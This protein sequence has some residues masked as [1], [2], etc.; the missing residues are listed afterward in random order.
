MEQRNHAGGPAEPGKRG[1]H[2]VGSERL[3]KFDAES[4]K[5]PRRSTEL[6]DHLP[7]SLGPFS[8]QNA[9][10]A[11]SHQCNDSCVDVSGSFEICTVGWFTRI[12]RRGQLPN[13]FSVRLYSHL[14]QSIDSEGTR[15]SQVA[16]KGIARNSSHFSQLF[17][18]YRSVSGRSARGIPP[19]TA[20]KMAFIFLN[21][22][23]S[24]H[25]VVVGCILRSN[26]TDENRLLN[27]FRR[28][29]LQRSC[30]VSNVPVELV[31]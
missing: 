26:V 6:R 4:E 28:S 18:A 5:G 2:S 16:C 17:E 30:P 15:N 7:T 12:I 1:L 3:P 22:L 27:V 25:P 29:P 14:T 23:P 21:R 20:N 8:L 24:A 19:L 9:P 10:S 13:S 31:L 11:L